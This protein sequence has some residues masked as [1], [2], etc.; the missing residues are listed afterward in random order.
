M[1][2]AAT[3]GPGSGIAFAILALNAILIYA[4]IRPA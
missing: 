3:T 1:R 4:A 2:S